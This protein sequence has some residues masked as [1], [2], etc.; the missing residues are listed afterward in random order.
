MNEESRQ[1]AATVPAAAY[2]SC[3]ARR[4]ALRLW[5]VIAI[6]A[7][8]IVTGAVADVRICIVGLMVLFIIFPAAMSL[9]VL[10]Y[11]LRP[12]VV[13]LTRAASASVAGGAL[14]VSDAGGAVLAVVPLAR[15]RSIGVS[16]GRD[17]IIC[18]ASPADV[19]ILPAGM[20][21]PGERSAIA[22]AVPS[23]TL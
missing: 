10:G 12:S 3:I 8:A 16:S 14:T 21:T 15:V 22:D 1:A 6:A 20:L 9:A 13:A 2:T 11:A 4:V 23:S 5:W 18:G 19:V 7:A 17:V